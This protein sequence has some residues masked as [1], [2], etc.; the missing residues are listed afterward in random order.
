[1]ESGNKHGST[2]KLPDE[3]D[4][5]CLPHSDIL[6]AVEEPILYGKACRL[7]KLSPEDLEKVE[8]LCECLMLKP[9]CKSSYSP[10]H[11]I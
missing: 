1:M 2:L 6:C 9:N 3:V 7:Y 5:L 11:V 4:I 10:S 8:N